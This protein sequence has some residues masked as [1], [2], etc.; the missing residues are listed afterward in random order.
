VRLDVVGVDGE[1]PLGGG[2]R[3]LTFIL[4]G[5]QRRPFGKQLGGVGIER[6]RPLE[7]G[8]GARA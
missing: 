6:L 7:R 3:L 4:P 1:R 2:S 5:M 8:D